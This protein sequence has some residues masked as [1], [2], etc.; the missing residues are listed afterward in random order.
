MASAVFATVA[1]HHL[2]W[3]A[4][5][6]ARLTGGVISFQRVGCIVCFNVARVYCWGARRS[7]G[8]ARCDTLAL[9]TPTLGLVVRGVVDHNHTGSPPARSTASEATA[10]LR[11]KRGGGRS[12]IDLL[13]LDLLELYSRST[14]VDG[15]EL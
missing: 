1:Q 7:C 9:A 10:Y 6:A 11:A 15:I 3:V 13:Y 12:T 4:T 8:A 2:L 5:A 14:S